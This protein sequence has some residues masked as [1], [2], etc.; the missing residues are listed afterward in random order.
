MNPGA[1]DWPAW[2]HD[3]DGRHCCFTGSQLNPAQHMNPGAHDWPA[4]LHDDDGRHCCFPGSQLSPAQHACPPPQGCPDWLHIA[5]AHTPLTQLPEQQSLLTWHGPIG[6]HAGA[7]MPPTQLPMQHG[8]LPPH[9]P[10]VGAHIGGWQTPPRQLPEQHCALD[11]HGLMSGAQPGWQAP[12]MHCPWQQSP[13]LV[14]P[15]P[16]PAQHVIAPPHDSP[17]QQP[18]PHAAP[19]A[20]Q[21]A[22]APP[23]HTPEQ[24]CDPV[25]HAPIAGAQQLPFEVLHVRPVAHAA[26]VMPIAPQAAP[27]SEGNGTQ[28]PF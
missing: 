25:V 10:P 8:T 17:L 3:D 1:H 18:M 9:F 5:D 4:W 27:V 26:H 23:V 19:R 28:L 6:W 16:M 7:Q 2:L 20:L 21:G 11:M 12:P 14:H 22:Q 15:A 24:H 13:E